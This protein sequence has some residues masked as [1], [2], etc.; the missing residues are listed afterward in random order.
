MPSPAAS[1]SSGVQQGTL[2][3]SLLFLV[4]I[5][6]L[7]NE[8]ANRWKFVDDMSLLKKCR[9]NTKS[10]AMEILEDVASE[11]A[12]SKMKVN[13]RKSHIMTF[14]FLKSKPSFIAP[15]PTEIIRTKTNLLGVTLTSDLKWDAH[16]CSIV[17]QANTSLSLLKLFTNFS[18]PKAH[19][20]RLYSS[21]IR[22]QL[23][24]A[25]PVWHNGLTV[26]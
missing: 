18:H 1:T 25:C 17:K 2:I 14:S 10:S 4:M 13:S 11:A 12:Q 3:G 21:Y 9:K 26:D 24:Y 5:N 20:L 8:S 6:S 16:I 22:P 19:I 23:E 15:I 7:T